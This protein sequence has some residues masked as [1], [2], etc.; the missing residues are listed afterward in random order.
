MEIGKSVMT[1][2]ERIVQVRTLEDIRDINKGI[3][4]GDDDVFYGIKKIIISIT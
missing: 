2:I 3:N 1:V 4:F